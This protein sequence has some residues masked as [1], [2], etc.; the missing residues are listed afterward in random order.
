MKKSFMN[1]SRFSLLL[2]TILLVI[3]SITYGREKKQEVPV[4]APNLHAGYTFNVIDD[5]IGA[6]NYVFTSNRTYLELKIDDYAAP[7]YWYTATVTM[8][9]EPA[10]DDGS[11]G[12]PY[13]VILTVVNNHYGGLGGFVDMHKHLVSTPNARGARVTITNVNIVNNE[14]GAPVIGIPANLKLSGSFESTRF[15]ELNVDDVPAITVTQNTASN[16]IDFSWNNDITG[17]EEYELEWTWVDN[18]SDQSALTVLAASDIDFNL[19]DFERNN[20]RIQTTANH[21]S[22]SNIYDRG[23]LIY[24]LRNVGRFVT[25]PTSI[26]IP[27]AERVKHNLYGRWSGSQTPNKVS[28]WDNI[29]IDGHRENLNWQFQSSYAEEGKKKEVASYFD[30]SLRNRQ[31]V[32][33]T[34]TNEKAIV[35]EVIYDNEGRPAVEVLPAPVNSP[36]IDY[37]PQFNKNHA[38]EVYSYQDFVPLND[39]DCN[40]PAQD[41]STS[42]G[43]S[44]YYSDNNAQQSNMQDFVPK[45]EAYPFSQTVYSNDNT[46]RIKSKGGVGSQFQIQSGHATKYFYTTPAPEELNRLFGYYVGNALHYKK[47]AV[48][49]PNGQL[50]VTYLDPQGRT[51]A[52]ALAADSPPNM[53]ALEDDGNTATRAELTEDLLNKL[54]STDI[55]TDLDNNI[56]YQTGTFGNL[57]DGLRY[58]AQKVLT[59]SSSLYT[60]NYTLNNPDV[61]NFGC[62]NINPAFQVT[63]PFVYKLNI[64][65]KNECGVSQITPI[66]LHLGASNYSVDSSGNVTTTASPISIAQSFG[67]TPTEPALYSVN[68]DLTVDGDALEI[69]TEDYIKKATA[70]G[71]IFPQQLAQAHYEGC[72]ANCAECAAHYD[73]MSYNSFIGQAAYV[74][75]MLDTNSDL[76]DLFQAAPNSADYQSLLAILTTRYEREWTGLRADCMRPCTGT[77]ASNDPNQTP[78]TSIACSALFSQIVADVMP[79]GQYANGSSIVSS[80]GQVLPSQTPVDIEDLPLSVYN[81][82][83]SNHLIA[84]VAGLEAPSVAGVQNN[85]NWR[86]PNYFDKNNFQPA[87]LNHYFTENGQIDYVILTRDDEGHYSPE[88]LPSET[89]HIIYTAA[90][91]EYK[92]EPQ[93]LK[94]V[95]D[96]MAKI[97]SK[98]S[99]ALS[100]IKYHPEFHYIE[101]QLEYC[102]AYFTKIINLAGVSYNV[103][104]DGFDALLGSADTYQEAKDKGFITATNPTILAENDPFFQTVHKLDAYSSSISGTAIIQNAATLTDQQLY[105]Q[106][107]LSMIYQALAKSSP[108]GATICTSDVLGF[109][110]GIGEPNVTIARSAY[111]LIRCTGI[112]PIGCGDLP[113]GATYAQIIAKVELFEESEKNRFWQNY[114]SNYVGLKQTIKDTFINLYAA[115]NGGYN[116]CI[117]N[118]AGADLNNITLPIAERYPC[119]KTFVTTQLTTPTLVTPNSCS[120]NGLSLAPKAKRFIF[121]QSIS[122]QNSGGASSGQANSNIYTQTGICPMVRDLEI[123]L[124]SSSKRSDFAPVYR[125]TTP[126][127]QPY[128]NYLTAA[129]L[130]EMGGVYNQTL[131]SS[132][133]MGTSTPANK[134]VNLNFTQNSTPLKSITL[135]IP[136]T[137]NNSALTWN[138][139]GGNPGQWKIVKMSNLTSTNY[140]GIQQVY[141]FKVLAKIT[142]DGITFFERVFDGYTPIR[143]TCTTGA[144]LDPSQGNPIVLE[145]LEDDDC[146]KKQNFG[147]ALKSLMQTLKNTNH[148]FAT[149]PYTVT[150]PAYLKTYFGVESSAHTASWKVLETG[151][152]GAK[153]FKLS[154]I[155]SGSLVD[156]G[157]IIYRNSQTTTYSTSTNS[158]IGLSIGNTDD[159][160]NVHTISINFGTVTFEGFIH[161]FSAQVDLLTGL[162]LKPKMYFACCSPCGEYDYDADGIGDDGVF[163]LGSCD[164]CDNRIDLDNNG[165]GDCPT[166]SEAA[167][168]DCDGILNRDDNCPLVYNPEQENNGDTDAFG[169]V[170]DLCPTHNDV[171]NIDTDGDG[172]GDGCDLCPLGACPSCF[173][174]EDKTVFETDFKNLLNDIISN[175]S[176][177]NINTGIYNTLPHLDDFY[178]NYDLGSRI[179]N[180]FYVSNLCPANGPDPG[181]EDLE[182]SDMNF[183]FAK[184]SFTNFPEKLRWRKQAATNGSTYNYLQYDI[185]TTSNGVPF[186]EGPVTIIDSVTLVE[187][188][189][190][191]ATT[192]EVVIE[193]H[194]DGEFG[195]MT[196]QRIMRIKVKLAK[197]SHSNPGHMGDVVTNVTCNFDHPLCQF[198]NN[199]NNCRSQAGLKKIMTNTEFSLGNGIQSTCPCIPHPPVPVA[200]GEQYD[201]FMQ[202]MTTTFGA[203]NDEVTYFTNKQDFFCSH[204]L[205]YLVT[206]YL[207][208]LSAL[209]ITSTTDP[210]YIAID[211]FGATGLNYG[212]S[213]YGTV[214]TAYDAYLDI[215]PTDPMNWRDFV[216]DYL[217]HHAEICPPA[218]MTPSST[219]SVPFPEHTTCQE[220]SLN[221]AESYNDDNYQAY[222]NAKKQA[223]KIAYLAQALTKVKET[224]TMKYTDKEYQYTLYY[225]DQAGNLMQ[226]VAPQGVGIVPSANSEAVDV[227]RNNNEPN[228]SPIPSLLPAQSFQTKYR[229]N[230]LNQLVWQST[231]DGGETRFAYDLLGRIVASQNKKQLNTGILINP[232]I[233]LGVELS[234]K[235]GIIYNPKGSEDYKQSYGYSLEG[236]AESGYIEYTLGFSEGNTLD[237]ATRKTIFGLTYNRDNT[238]GSVDYAFLYD[239]ENRFRIHTPNGTPDLTYQGAAG[240]ILT[241][242]RGDGVVKF[243]K[244][245]ILI[246]DAQDKDTKKSLYLNFYLPITDNELHDLK[247][248]TLKSYRDFSYT[249]YDR[250]GRVSESGQ[251]RGNRFMSINDNGKLVFSGGTWVPVDAVTDTY[252][253]NV[254]DEQVEV[255]KTLYDNY[256]PFN[257]DTYLTPTPVRNVRNRV[258]A[259]L[260]FDH[261]DDTTLLTD[262]ETAIFYNYDI[263]GNVDEMSQRLSPNVMYVESEPDGVVKK[264][265]YEYDLISGNVNKVFYQKGNLDDQFIHKYNYDAD[266]R[267]TSVE[268]SRDNVIWEKDAT[269]QYYQHGPLARVIRG[270]KKVQGTDFAYTLQGWIKTVNSE[271]LRSLNNDMGRDG[272]Y[273]SKDAFGYS[274]SYYDR[275]YEARKAPS[276]NDAHHISGLDL[277]QL[278]GV[279]LYDGNINRVITSVRGI[280]E[281]ILPTQ[282]NLYR[283][284][285]LNRIF[286]LRSFNGIQ[287]SDGFTPIDS[288]RSS[289]TYYKNGNLHRLDR[290]APKLMVADDPTSEQIVPMD[291]FT[292]NYQPGTNKLLN[293]EDGM[294]E[295]ARFKEDIDNQPANNYKYDVLGQLVSDVTGNINKIDWRVDGKVKSINKSNSKFSINFFYDGLGNRVAKQVTRYKKG[296]V[297]THYTNDAQG[298]PMGVYELSINNILGEEPLGGVGEAEYRLLEHNIY[299]SSRLGIQDY[300]TFR[301]PA[302]SYFERFVGDKRYELSNHLGNVLSV[303]SDRKLVNQEIVPI[304]TDNFDEDT[305]GWKYFNGAKV[306]VNKNRELQ[307]T[308]KDRAEYAGAEK[309]AEFSKDKPVIF[310][311]NVKRLEGFPV[312]ATVRFE[313]LDESLNVVWSTIVQTD[314]VFS[315][316]FTPSSDGKFYMRLSVTNPLDTEISYSLDD[317]YAYRAP[318][319]PI[320]YVSLF[321]P[322]VLN[323]NDYY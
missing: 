202:T 282:I 274:L 60:F 294:T 267:I 177:G 6:T 78:T 310:N 321:T 203:S 10:F 109:T 269:Y 244:N 9:V 135:I 297:T 212:Y 174:G 306:D 75:Q 279:S 265:K 98:Q 228:A 85:L 289:Y 72:Y 270:D 94:N 38:G 67:I 255:T 81:D 268:T 33:K 74:H 16:T 313:V 252:P 249:C 62:D 316:S 28:D 276:S 64:D 97:Q 156:T 278:N 34:N 254:S 314:E 232:P 223:F 181:I 170:C 57:F 90:I 281:E 299:G 187:P 185:T 216:S 52:S 194:Y 256:G 128:I 296:T 233:G 157:I 48:L 211:T 277:T 319:N 245:G 214:I 250:L 19:K 191:S 56:K 46:G 152:G 285:Q 183:S 273:V 190:S 32:T 96:F 272:N 44:Q 179:Q 8:S 293:I 17:V 196:F 231:P 15:Y 253:H 82:T 160:E 219:I 300:K 192:Q 70:N 148:L 100:L 225:Y 257:P 51:I 221:V 198:V 105:R 142:T 176:S 2:I 311:M 47:N 55:D 199:C 292:Y 242:E 141:N 280:Q 224:F 63:Y 26:M 22:I 23:Y 207:Q 287:N 134:I 18:Y 80:S 73:Q 66:D 263:H 290:D 161:R 298:N 103:N 120:V 286:S 125:G 123:F 49:D 27:V 164:F 247:I 112:G 240:D 234:D 104:S 102:K 1:S 266:N 35:G 301:R 76:N 45:A 226:T 288:Y 89:G 83:A 188:A 173:Q 227:M 95:S 204:N 303:I 236:I 295:T 127:T 119:E 271:N 151:T 11:F 283:Y 13:D 107:K 154:V 169:D 132:G 200:C 41:M 318:W 122:T 239:S 40:V 235:E 133:T 24:R 168:L 108:P 77:G 218:P 258:A 217:S 42:S 322:D 20:T 323:Y 71:C 209:G 114:M 308:L 291:Q 58:G 155:K 106:Y 165:V 145:P 213:N 14:T 129:L 150:L 186:F 180:N 163:A 137:P 140:D 5:E 260:T 238:T 101:Y 144:P 126:P 12:T 39:A 99:W 158:I 262:N 43:A 147:D 222:L 53:I 65:V 167:D 229:Y 111:E 88:V 305:G 31:T 230:S 259:I 159:T 205:Q 115:R 87:S 275:D 243:Y 4:A 302:P 37:Y 124:D 312:D 317:F 206:G 241:I 3:S 92:V 320:N 248:A 251:F 264:V 237:K 172:L 93:Y 166:C 69:F 201:L 30:G 220:F 309:V 138:N 189:N 261:T 84:I 121:L 21:Y 68:K 131:I 208:Y 110:S 118:T 197:F 304:A 7:Y 193:G 149:T 178:I 184:G 25:N 29:S 36:A 307:I 215:T 162:T 130:T 182:L 175:S 113:A 54:H 246:M 116:D 284:D 210:R 153:K 315:D 61:F 79:G 117:G 50:S 146:D 139:Y 59:A 143:L 86:H 171:T 195:S 136:N 91:D